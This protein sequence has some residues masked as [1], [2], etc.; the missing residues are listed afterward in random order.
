MKGGSLNQ[1]PQHIVD[2]NISQEEANTL[3]TLYAAN[4]HS[5]GYNI[6][7]YS[8]DTDA[9]VLAWHH[10]HGNGDHLLPIYNHLG[11]Y[12]AS[13]QPGLD[14]TISSCD[15]TGRLKGKSKAAWG[16]H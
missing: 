5:N 3:L 12:K 13:A 1:Q 4:L 9:M 11:K 15:M 7:I 6:P 8:S 2:L 10:Y 14:Y 16:L